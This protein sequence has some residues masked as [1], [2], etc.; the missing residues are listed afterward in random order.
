MAEESSKKALNRLHSRF[1]TA[2]N[3]KSTAHGFLSEMK[4]PERQHQYDGPSRKISI[5]LLVR[6]HFY[7]E[8]FNNLYM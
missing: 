3:S 8:V 5:L 2:S 7:L 6:V 4:N 1:L